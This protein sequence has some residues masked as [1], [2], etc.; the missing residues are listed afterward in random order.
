LTAPFYPGKKHVSSAF[1]ASAILK[2]NN[3]QVKARS[4]FFAF[5]KIAKKTYPLRIIF[6]FYSYLNSLESRTQANCLHVQKKKPS[7]LPLLEQKT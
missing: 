2:N 5:R 4:G 3:L 7:K 1:L 6:P